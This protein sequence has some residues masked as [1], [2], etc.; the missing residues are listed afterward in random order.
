M[1]ILPLR[2]EINQG[3]K[4]FLTLRFGSSHGC[5]IRKTK[6]HKD[7]KEEIKLMLKTDSMII[8]WNIKKAE[9]RTIDAFELWYWRRLLRATWTERRSNQSIL[10]EIHPEY[11][12][13]GL[14]LKLKLQ[15]FGHLMQ[16]TDS[17]E[18][19]L[20]L[21]KIEGRRRGRERMRWL[22]DITN[23]VDMSLNKLRELV[24]DR[25]AWRV[26][27]HGAVKSQTWLSDWTE[28][29]NCEA[30]GINWYCPKQ[31]KTYVHSNIISFN[32]L[33]PTGWVKDREAWCV[34]V[35][36]VKNGH[37]WATQQHHQQLIRIKC[38]ASLFNR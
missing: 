30:A 33:S 3:C 5:N 34:A 11:S 21:G 29:I 2:S 20:M 7:W 9:W 37:D 13:E 19:I 14:M 36:G 17:L 35:P 15:Y 31:R 10:K 24:M 38:P 12:L 18:K 6:R 8:Y 32:P 23:S 22:D 16:R 1:K 4:F 28:P 26:A 25:E 27:V